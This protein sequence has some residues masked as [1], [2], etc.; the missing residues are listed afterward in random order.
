MFVHLATLGLIA[1]MVSY[2]HLVVRDSTV[3]QAL[4]VVS[5]ALLVMNAAMLLSHRKHARPAHTL[6][7]VLWCV[8]VALARAF[9]LTVLLYFS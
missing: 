8:C 1:L 2:P 4:R 7:L 3:T 9:D 6:N 5:N